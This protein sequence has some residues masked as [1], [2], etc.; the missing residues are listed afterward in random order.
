MSTLRTLIV[1]DEPLARQTL[2]ILLQPDNSIEVVGEAAD[3]PSAIQAIRELHPDLVFL[4]I[5]MPGCGGFDVI[6]AAG[7]RGMAVVF[8]TAYDEYAVEAFRAEALDY[9]LK[10]FDD[11][12]FE[13]V[14]RRV[15]ER[16]TERELS[17]VG[18]RLS[19]YFSIQ[20]RAASAES[21]ATRILVRGRGRMTILSAADIE[22]VQAADNYIEI[23]SGGRSY[24][25]RQTMQEFERKLD[26]A[27]FFRVHRSVI[28][29]L[30]RVRELRP[31]DH[32]E[33]TA[34][35]LSGAQVAV[36]RVRRAAL[37]KTLAALFEKR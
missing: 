11:R 28:V 12:R 5:R 9:L 37:E 32:G 35:L 25:L 30:D 22:W 26:P 4:D 1:D 15:K 24:L 17:A 3:G 27:T 19:E 16:F 33:A 29:N 34:I 18:L 6:Q 20:S 21:F 14:M 36:S 10:P 7:A 13:Q 23:H 2:R 8:V 31:H